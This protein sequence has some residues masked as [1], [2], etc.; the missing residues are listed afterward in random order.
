MPVDNVSRVKE[1]MAIDIGR[2][3]EARL[4]PAEIV[5]RL[6]TIPELADA[7][8]LLEARRRPLSSDPGTREEKMEIVDA[9]NRVAD[10]LDDGGFHED[11][12]DNLRVIAAM[13]HPDRR[14]MC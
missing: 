8:H 7:F 13:L 10:W 5:A 14:E 6:F 2:F 11:L 4:P 1:A 3:S 9:I 12:V